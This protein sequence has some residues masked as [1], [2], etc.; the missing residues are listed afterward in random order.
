MEFA[1]KIDEEIVQ[2]VREN[3]TIAQGLREGNIIYVC[4]LP[5]QTRE[6]LD[7]K[8]DKMKNFYL[9]YCPW[10][11]GALK[12]GTEK[13]IT[14]DFCHCSAGWYK[15]YWDQIFGQ[16][17]KVEPIKTARNGDMECKFAIHLPDDLLKSIK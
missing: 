2:F 17:I 1:Q 13:E 9:C 11:R 8:D 10:I 4:K 15:L 7:A 14:K 5:Y 16:S 3:K 12:N 6:F